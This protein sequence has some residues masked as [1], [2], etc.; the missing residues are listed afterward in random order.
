LR[1]CEPW[2]P[3]LGIDNGLDDLYGVVRVEGSDNSI[4]GNHVSEVIDAASIRPAGARPVVIRL[5]SGSGNYVATNH[6]VARD[7][8]ASS[9][10][11]AFEAQV[12]ALLSTTASETLAVT[13][14]SIDPASGANTILD[15]GTEAEVLADRSVNAVRP[16]PVV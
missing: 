11:S 15:T 12:D 14:V 2:T 5:A 10:G 9:G 4:I 13:V 16:M 7:V 1:D 3:F 8:H 6:V